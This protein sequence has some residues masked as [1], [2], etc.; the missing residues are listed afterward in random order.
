[1]VAVLFDRLAKQVRLVWHKTFTPTADEAV[2]FAAVEAALLELHRKFSVRGICYDPWQFAASSQRLRL[3]GLPMREV[4]QTSANLTSAS[5][6]LFELITSNNLVVYPSRDLRDAV[7]HATVVE[8]PRGMRIAK[9]TRNA[10]IDLVVALA[11]ACSAAMEGQSKPRGFLEMSGW[12]SDA[13]EKPPRQAG[14]RVADPQAVESW[15]RAIY[16]ESNG[17]WWG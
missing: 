17:Q 6:T 7:A 8:G 9:V 4:A 15:C 1:V 11:L 16:V 2:D 3:Q 14:H 5:A 13:E 10:R 12:E